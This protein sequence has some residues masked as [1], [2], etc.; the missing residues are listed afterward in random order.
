MDE[1]L[2]RETANHFGLDYVGVVGVLIEAK[3]RG[4]VKSI[5]SC[6]D[7]FRDGAGFRISEMLYNRVLQDEGEA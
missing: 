3:H 5:K 2:G 6:L 1:R 4:L 7:R